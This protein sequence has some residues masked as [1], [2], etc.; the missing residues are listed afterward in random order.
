MTT[1]KPTPTERFPFGKNWLGFLNVL[2][3]AHIAE[4][5][6]SLMEFLDQI[7]IAGKRFLDIGSG[8]GNN[9]FLFSQDQRE[10]MEKVKR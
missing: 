10:L 5:E 6:R 3:E 2:T 1:T 8:S 9:Q 4:A 7:N